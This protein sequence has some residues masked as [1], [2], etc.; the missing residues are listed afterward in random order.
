MF[1][2]I[3]D[4]LKSLK[5]KSIISAVDIFSDVIDESSSL[6]PF[7]QLCQRYVAQRKV[8]RQFLNNLSKEKMFLYDQV[9]NKVGTPII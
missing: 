4:I 6:T 5:E 7:V 8:T 1:E 2:K 9:P 3:V